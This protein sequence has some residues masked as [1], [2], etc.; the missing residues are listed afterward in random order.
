MR[1]IAI[2]GLGGVGGYFGGLLAKG[3]EHSD[4]IEIYF[5]A[6]GENERIIDKNGLRLE[7]YKG[8]FTIFPKKVTSDPSSL[9]KVDYIICC[10]KNYDIEQSVIQLHSCIDKR[11]IIIPLMN[12][13]EGHALIKNI[14]PENEVW[15]SCVYLVSELIEP[16]FV[17]QTGNMESLYFGSNIAAPSQLQEVESI[18][19]N[20][21]INAAISSDIEQTVWIKFIFISA[22]A[23]IT[24]FLDASIGEI[25]ADQSGRNQLLSLLT[26]IKAVADAKNISLPEDIIKITTDKLEGL[27]Y[28][29]TSSMHTDFIK[30]KSTEL[31]SLTGYIIK[32]GKEYKINTPTYNMMYEG[33]MNRNLKKF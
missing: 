30:G 15:D 3:Y 5:I 13:F 31:H 28:K 11:T 6:R 9:G 8:N 7:T 19:L 4:Q 26:E 18:F 1:K 27:P 22:L 16:G 25:L 2:F 33:L 17:K 12:G 20:A 21:N 23:T 10:T 14:F 24:S 32:A 29:T